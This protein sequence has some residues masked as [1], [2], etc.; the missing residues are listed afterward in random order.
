MS[1]APA[2]KHRAFAHIQ[3]VGLRGLHGQA[4]TFSPVRGVLIRCSADRFS[5][6]GLCQRAR[7]F[8]SGKLI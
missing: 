2:S 7:P 3:S 5:S 6:E 4:E 8:R 1:P